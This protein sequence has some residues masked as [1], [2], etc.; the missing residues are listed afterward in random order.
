MNLKSH[1]IPLPSDAD[2]T[3]SGTSRFFH[4]WT[5]QHPH[6]LSPQRSLGEVGHQATSQC[7]LLFI[8]MVYYGELPRQE[9]VH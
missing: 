7:L 8:M 3:A 9:A 1:G 6:F 4:V 5:Y 2:E